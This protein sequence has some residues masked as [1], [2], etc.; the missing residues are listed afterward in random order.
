MLDTNAPV[1]TSPHKQ[2]LADE[3][4]AEGPDA[5]LPAAERASDAAHTRNS[6]EGTTLKPAHRQTCAGLLALQATVAQ[7]LSSSVAQPT[8]PNAVRR[9]ARREGWTGVQKEGKPLPARRGAGF[10]GHAGA[11]LV[12]KSGLSAAKHAPLAQHAN[13]GRA[14]RAKQ[15]ARRRRLRVCAAI[16]A[17]ISAAMVHETT[18]AFAPN[19]RSELQAA[20]IGCVG[21]CG[22]A[23]SGSGDGTY[24]SS[25]SWISGT[26][27]PCNNAGAGVPGGQGSGTYGVIGDWDVAKVTIMGPSECLVCW[28]MAHICSSRQSRVFL[29]S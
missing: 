16:A 29:Y 9:S 21:A 24:C 8:P 12:H 6:L 25:G 18:A 28:P 23:L 26:G 3:R 1:S 5:E 2:L 11:N 17:T 14:F 19:S 20:T 7:P 4:A 15:C 13:N 22:R 10:A 27:N